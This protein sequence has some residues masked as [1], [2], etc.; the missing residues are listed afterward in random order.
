MKSAEEWV[1]KYSQSGPFDMIESTEEAIE[2]VKKIQE[3]AMRAL[4]VKNRKLTRDMLRTKTAFDT[5]MN[6]LTT[7]DVQLLIDNLIKERV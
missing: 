2:M 5:L 1:E 7:F 4:I 6:D 3:D